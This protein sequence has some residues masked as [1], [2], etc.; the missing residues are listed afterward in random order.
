M[1]GDEIQDVDS[2]ISGYTSLSHFGK[3]CVIKCTPRNEKLEFLRVLRIIKQDIHCLSPA[4]EQFLFD[5]QFEIHERKKDQRK[6]LQ[7]NFDLSNPTT[8]LTLS[9]FAEPEVSRLLARLKQQSPEP[10]NRKIYS[11]KELYS[12][13]TGVPYKR[14]IKNYPAFKA[15]LHRKANQ[16]TLPEI[17]HCG[18]KGHLLMLDPQRTIAELKLERGQH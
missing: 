6:S 11:F 13:I 15:W 14:G 18:K 1:S 5:Y 10:T 7:R 9:V 17:G 4:D 8:F 2:L 3:Q 16:E 12:T